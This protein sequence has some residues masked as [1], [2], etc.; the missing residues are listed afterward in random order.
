[1]VNG[2]CMS[3]RMISLSVTYLLSLELEIFP[4]F[5]LA[6]FRIFSLCLFVSL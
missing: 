3:C 2:E 1:M 6:Y 4:Y 5:S